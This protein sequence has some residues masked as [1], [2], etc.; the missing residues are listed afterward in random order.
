[1]EHPL[2]P[3]IVYFIEEKGKRYRYDDAPDYFEGGDKEGVPDSTGKLGLGKY[4]PEVG[5][6]HPGGRKPPGHVETLK[7]DYHAVERNIMKNKYNY[8]AGQY[9]HIIR[10]FPAQ[11]FL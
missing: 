1:L 6:P 4:L 3:D 5:K 9:Q 8:D 11:G 2:Y 10:P 7:G